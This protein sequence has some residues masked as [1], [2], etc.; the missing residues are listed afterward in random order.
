MDPLA[1]LALIVALIAFL[2]VRRIMNNK[3]KMKETKKLY[4]MLTSFAPSL[5]VSWS[6]FTFL[7]M[8]REFFR[9]GKKLDATYA[10]MAMFVF[11]LFCTMVLIAGIIEDLRPKKTNE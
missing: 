5:F 4:K 10:D 7:F 11:G 2:V 6:V 8:T 1:I 9:T 3:N